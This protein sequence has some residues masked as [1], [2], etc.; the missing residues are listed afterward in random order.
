M[1]KSENLR[2][3]ARVYGAL[4]IL[5]LIIGTSEIGVATLVVIATIIAVGGAVLKELGH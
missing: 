3:L 4:A 1:K 2:Y 5:G